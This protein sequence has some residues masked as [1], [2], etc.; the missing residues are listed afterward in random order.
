MTAL[1]RYELAC[2]SWLTADGWLELATTF[3]RAAETHR[4]RWQG[5]LALRAQDRAADCRARAAA[6]VA[7][8]VSL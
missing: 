4:D 1:A 8:A 2:E 3:D 5:G 6:I 7:G